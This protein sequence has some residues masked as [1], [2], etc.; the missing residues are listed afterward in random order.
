MNGSVVASD[1]EDVSYLKSELVNGVVNEFVV[2]ASFNLVEDDYR[3]F[4]GETEPVSLIAYKKPDASTALS[5]SNLA[6]SSLT[7]SWSP[8]SL[9]GTAHLKYKVYNGEVL[10]KESLSDMVEL[11]GLTKGKDYHLSVITV[12]TRD[13]LLGQNFTSDKSLAIVTRPYSNPS[14]VRSL[15]AAVLDRSLQIFWLEP[16][17]FGGY[18]LLK[19]RL[20]YLPKINDGSRWV[21]I[22]GVESGVVLTRLENG[23]EYQV[24]VIV[25]TFNTELQ[26]PLNS[27]A[28]TVYGMPKSVSSS[29]QNM[30]VLEQ[31][32]SFKVSCNN[33]TIISFWFIPRNFKTSIL[34]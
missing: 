11:T 21:T 24:N 1:L 6:S 19:Y 15:S 30:V 17:D 14:K 2:K 18:P 29:P 23:K 32:G 4:T 25:D 33:S 10:V 7:L 13:E 3:T 16:M 26:L 31:D 28:Q 5:V 34:F 27:G 12:S 8:G 22:D 20:M 9:N